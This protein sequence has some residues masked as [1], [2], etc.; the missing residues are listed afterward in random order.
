MAQRENISPLAGTSDQDTVAASG[1]EAPGIAGSGCNDPDHGID[2]VEAWVEDAGDP[3]GSSASAR[4]SWLAPTLA[5]MAAAGWTGFYGWAMQSEVLAGRAAPQAWAQMI[6][7]WAVPVLL[8]AVAYLVVMRNS[9]AE[10]AGF[11]RSAAMLRDESARLEQRLK[12]VN[13]ELS[14]AREFLGSQ[15]QELEALGR[16]AVE[17]IA[18]H[19]DELQSLI[20]DNNDQVTAIAMASQTALGNMKVLRDNLPVVAN[21]ARDAANQIGN[22]GRGAQE[23]VDKLVGAFEQ[24][25]QFADNSAQQVAGLSASTAQT[26][27]GL[28]NQVSQI[29]ASLSQRL[30]SLQQE[31]S[32]YA[33]ELAAHE[34]EAMAALQAR[35]DAL[36]DGAARFDDAIGAR[37]RAFAEQA[38]QTQAAFDLREAQ[39]SEVLAQRLAE[40]DDALAQRREAQIAETEKLV[41]HNAA[42]TQQL[43]ELDDLLGRITASSASARSDLGEGLG[44]LAEQLDAQRCAL[45]ETANTLAALTD[46]GVRLLEIIQS[47]ARFTNDDLAGNIAAADGQLANV[48]TKASEVQGLMLSSAE[49]GEKLDAYL[50]RTREQITASDAA[51]SEFAANLE[52][53]SEE[54]LARLNGLRGAFERL[55]EESGALAAESQ[56]QLRSSLGAIEAA[57]TQSLA[58]L[59][60]GTQEQL[61]KLAKTMG[62]DTVQALE[63]ALRTEAA[64][65]LGKLEQ[66]AAHAAGVGRETAVQLRDQ[67]AMVNELTGN[68]EQRIER[69]RELA[70]E[71]VNNDFARRMA[72]ITDSLNS[73]SIDIS[74]A[75]STE[76]SDTAWEAYLKGDR[77]IFTRRVV[78]LIDSGEAREIADLYQRDDA[79]R[80]NVSRYIHDFEAMLRSI[81]STRNGNVL[82]V[83]VLGSDIGKLYVALAQAIQR[84]RT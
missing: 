79:F 58:Q 30:A 45:D 84:L 44:T 9:R 28:A 53:H 8:V 39:A 10:A 55:A 5:I 83:T 11:A 7:Q 69:A 14:L 61:G 50:I 57:I 20:K 15:S 60:T 54:G 36:A 35:L 3:P 42:L 59:E 80:A 49:Q 12:V 67:L 82:S 29:E 70:E 65:T 68:L 46:S 37:A 23:Q 51:I 6:A 48:Q 76:I 16:I 22:A 13:R 47:S 43:G 52:H 38:E 74:N 64:V 27:E 18:K 72:L 62:T 66:S 4:L 17:R 21:S 56:E 1:D 33:G 77:G 32:D 19:A 63:Q 25:N 40:L 75:L 73:A 24:L 78:R 81:L 26:V 41:A 71:Q 31:S 34:S 2:L